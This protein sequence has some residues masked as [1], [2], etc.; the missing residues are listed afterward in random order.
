MDRREGWVTMRRANM[1]VAFAGGVVALFLTVFGSVH[2]AVREVVHRE[3]ELQISEPNSDLNRHM[4]AKFNGT[5]A[6]ERAN[7]TNRL[8]QVEKDLAVLKEHERAQTEEIRELR[9]DIKE[10]LRRSN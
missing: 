7:V 4:D 6:L 8:Q 2:I 3:M 1:I 5:C 9:A 10:L